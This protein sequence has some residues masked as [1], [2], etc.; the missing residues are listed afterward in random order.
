M[1]EFS[2]STTSVLTIFIV[3]Y[4]VAEMKIFPEYFIPAPASVWEAFKEIALTGYR[5]GTLLQHLGDSL[6]RVISGFILACFIAIP[7]GMFMGFNWKIKAVFDPIVEFYRPLPPLAYYTILVIWLGIENESKITLLFLAAFPPLS[8][9]AMSAVAAV[10]M[11]RIHT[12][13]SLGAGRLQIFTHVIFPSCL[14][15]IFTGMRVSIGFTYTT[16]V[17][18]EIVAATSGIGWMVLDAGKF[19]RGDVMFM[20]I[21][22]MG[23]TGIILDRLIRIAEKI[24]IPWKGKG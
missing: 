11:E 18:S 8:I 15:G 2:I 22:V 5:G 21:F 13:R 19:L 6:F 1:I 12:A 14:P 23:I 4:V 20:G 24:I 9:S 3:W 7:L 16:L 17:S 10:P